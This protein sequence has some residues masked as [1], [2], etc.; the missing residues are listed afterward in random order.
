MKHLARGEAW[1]LCHSLLLIL[2]FLI[3]LQA[4]ASGAYSGSWYNP[5]RDGEGFHVEVL[6]D[7]QVLVIWFTYP[8][9]TSPAET[10]QAWILG[11]GTI[12][13]AEVTIV[14]AYKGRGPSFGD[15][16]DKDDLVIETWGDISLQFTG[17]N[18][19]TVS[20]A[21]ADGSGSIDVIRLT[22]LAGQAHAGRLPVGISGAW[23]EPATNGQGWFVEIISPSQALVY[24]FTYDAAGR[25]AW[26]LG[27]G[28][29]VGTSIIVR[30]SVKG[31]GTRFGE[32]FDKDDVIRSSFAAVVLEFKNCG[33]GEASFLTADGT[34][35]GWHQL[36]RLTSLQGKS[37]ET[38]A[39]VETG[40][41]SV[42]SNVA[43][44]VLTRYES[45]DGTLMDTFGSS[46]EDGEN[47]VASGAL[48]VLPDGATVRTQFSP[49]SD[50]Y[51]VIAGDNETRF[52][53]QTDDNGDRFATVLDVASETSITVPLEPG[54]DSTPSLASTGKLRSQA[55]A[56]SQSSTMAI[57]G[58]LAKIA[59]EH[60]GGSISTAD[61]DFIVGD[62]DV[63]T[64][65]PTQS[66]YN[67]RNALV[68]PS[69]V[70]ALG[71][72]DFVYQGT[73]PTDSA[74][75]SSGALDARCAKLPDSVKGY[76]E[77][78]QYSGQFC[79]KLSG[80][81]NGFPVSVN[82]TGPISTFIGCNVSREIAEEYC[83]MHE[84]KEVYQCGSGGQLTVTTVFR[85]PRSDLWASVGLGGVTAERSLSAPLSI[86]PGGG[87]YVFP[88]MVLPGDKASATLTRTVPGYVW[89]G[90]GYTAH[91]AVSCMPDG[92]QLTAK[93]L[94]NE[95]TFNCIVDSEQRC[96]LSIPSTEPDWTTDILEVT[97][98]N[99][100]KTVL[101][102]QVGTP[103][104]SI[105]DLS[106][107]WMVNESGG[108]SS[109][110]GAF[111]E[112]YL[113]DV[114]QTGN[115]IDVIR[116]G[117][118]F[119]SGVR[120]GS[121]VNLSGSYPEDGGTTSAEVS[122]TVS[123][124]GYQLT[125]VSEWSWSDGDDVCSG[126]TNVIATRALF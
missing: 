73:I 22:S 113:A 1:R 15:G 125:G 111:S 51:E 31:V 120:T 32:S 90:F 45:P 98:P 124:D 85:K 80:L 115:A 41:L 54:P 11:T 47:V 106:G 63:S 6:P 101:S 61:V 76:C 2:L 68:V 58:Q 75:F 39:G 72:S 70:M 16:Y 52:I 34:V 77:V 69:S 18:S 104:F 92:A 59:V 17:D 126:N 86:N 114:I 37:C 26:N 93:R 30:D 48:A 12:E 102:V 46:D 108:S 40:T 66:N 79:A 29:I 99:D 28:D 38:F 123:G 78:G 42:M 87:D 4:A 24:W 60:C 8:G 23:Y 118:P 5:D 56:S 109:C 89:A 91:L 36:S 94:R 88:D 10:E 35:S 122:L 55:E 95:E 96:V 62:R 21:G 81:N 27:V 83:T 67:P 33:V 43:D 71:V 119:L 112:S 14:D 100:L 82:Q 19:A 97:G 117:Q 74:E 9:A 105:E 121:Q 84:L 44:P 53:F 20:Y 3:P 110:G 116:G 49:E 7:N 103:S 64:S 57:G 50:R 107:T 13:G 65:N 25:Q